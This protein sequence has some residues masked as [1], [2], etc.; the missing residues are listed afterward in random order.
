[1]VI[2]GVRA[3]V[4][5]PQDAFRFLSAELGQETMLPLLITGLQREW[6]E[7]RTGCVAG[8]AGW[9]AGGAGA[10]KSRIEIDKLLDAPLHVGVASALL[11]LEII[12]QRCLPS[13]LVLVWIVR[14]GFPANSSQ[15]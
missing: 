3:C 14:L 12:T 13:Q 6:Q 10:R 11:A 4:L 9:L 1:M 5:S 7:E 2:S 15:S 8:L